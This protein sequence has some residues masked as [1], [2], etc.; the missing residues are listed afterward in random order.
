[1]ALPD[2]SVNRTL[3]ERLIES[4]TKAGV[5]QQDAQAISDYANT[6]GVTMTGAKSITVEKTGPWT[7]NVCAGDAATEAT[8]VED[9][10]KAVAQMLH[11][12]SR[13][14]AAVD[15]TYVD[16]PKVPRITEHA[17]T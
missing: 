11:G 6:A 9:V 17:A 5:P 3:D 15:I 13:Q 12:E 8:S 10:L 14:V 7:F 2:N 4:L 1:M 16:D